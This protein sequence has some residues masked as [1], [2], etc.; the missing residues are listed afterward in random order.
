MLKIYLTKNVGEIT[1]KRLRAVGRAYDA[2]LIERYSNHPD[3]FQAEIE[4]KE[5]KQTIYAFALILRGFNL[6]EYIYD[7]ETKS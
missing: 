6:L 1:F 4:S 5:S 7:S 2:E 3:Y